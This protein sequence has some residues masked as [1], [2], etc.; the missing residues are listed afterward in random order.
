[1]SSFQQRQALS[2]GALGHTWLYSGQSLLVHIFS[3]LCL[4]RPWHTAHASA[5]LP[6]AHITILG[7]SRAVERTTLISKAK[8]SGV[9]AIC[10]SHCLLLT[11]HFGLNPVQGT[12]PRDSFVHWVLGMGLYSLISFP[13]GTER[14]K[15]DNILIWCFLAP[16]KDSSSPSAAQS[17]RS[18][19][20]P[21]HLWWRCTSQHVH[22]LYSVMCSTPFACTPMACAPLVSALGWTLCR[23]WASLMCRGAEDKLTFLWSTGH[24]RL[25][26]ETMSRWGQEGP[27]IW[28]HFVDCSEK[29]FRRKEAEWKG[30]CRGQQAGR[31]QG[32]RHNKGWAHLRGS[33][34]CM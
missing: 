21:R 5:L 18:P 24:Y 10:Q 34:P 20:S 27:W 30:Q 16:R 19:S 14:D 6:T 8:Q 7:V 26:S 3:S 4:S 2:R 15:R 13:Y 28:K 32:E 12:Q 22:H 31:R 11:V 23:M 33:C 25:L 9:V 17:C 1:M 29:Q